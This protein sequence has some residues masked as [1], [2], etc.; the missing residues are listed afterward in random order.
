MSQ[1]KAGTVAVT[2]GSASVVGTGT[3]WLANISTGSVFTI[4]GSKVPYVV[5][6]ITDD[7]HLTLA[8]NYAGL[9]ASGAAYVVQT[10]FTPALSL[11]YVEQ[12]DI[13]TA[14]ILKRAMLIIDQLCLGAPQ[15]SQSAN[16]T[17]VLADLGK[18]IYHPSSDTTARTWTIDSNANV[19]YPVG[20]KLT[21]INDTS[22][23]VITIAITADT[24]VLAGSGATG[25]RTLAAN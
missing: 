6:S 7:T 17:T 23:G 15:N 25:S 18:H 19:P 3:Q 16:Y 11:P 24:L 10:S 13:E 22:A 9:S 12:G 2:S 8:S 20:T 4:Q 14:T 21:F 5:G 1:Y